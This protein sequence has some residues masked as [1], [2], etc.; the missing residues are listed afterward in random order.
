MCDAGP[1]LEKLLMVDVDTLLTCVFLKQI[2]GKSN[3]MGVAYSI[4]LFN[5]QSL[6]L[7]SKC[8]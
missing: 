2:M 4:V 7:E 1:Y 5:R 8:G 6:Y 3:S